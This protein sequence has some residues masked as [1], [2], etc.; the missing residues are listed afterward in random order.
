M[1][2]GMRVWAVLDYTR[3]ICGCVYIC[4]SACVETVGLGDAHVVIRNKQGVHVCMY[5][6]VRICTTNGM[7]M[8]P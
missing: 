4:V 2:T 5:V 7:V 6:C 1:D 3:V 8:S